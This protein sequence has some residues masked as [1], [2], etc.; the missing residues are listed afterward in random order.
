MSLRMRS[1]YLLSQKQHIN[2]KCLTQA[3]LVRV[4]DGM[5]LVIWTWNFL[6]VQGFKI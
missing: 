2:T 3:E 5:P 1:V 4:N 6:Q